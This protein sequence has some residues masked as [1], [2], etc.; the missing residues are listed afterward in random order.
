M[1]YD[2]SYN[3]RTGFVLRITC[4]RRKK[5]HGGPWANHFKV[6]GRESEVTIGWHFDNAGHNY[7]CLRLIA[8][9]TWLYIALRVLTPMR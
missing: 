4:A 9:D 6:E 8:I 2:N 5:A 3:F 1:N 7:N